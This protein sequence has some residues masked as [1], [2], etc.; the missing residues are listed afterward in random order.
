MRDGIEPPIEKQRINEMVDPKKLKRMKKKLDELNRKI[1]HSRKKHDGMIHKRNA[2]RKAIEEIKRG[3]K[4]EVLGPARR[5]PWPSLSGILR[6]VSNFSEE[7]TEAI[8]LMEDRRWMLMH[9]SVE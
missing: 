9:S 1:S 2:L 3:T 6:S 4:P 7:L 8:G 5:S